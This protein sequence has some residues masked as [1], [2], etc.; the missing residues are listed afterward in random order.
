MGTPLPPIEPLPGV[1]CDRCWGSGATF[2]GG[3]PG[4]IILTLHDWTEGPLFNELFRDELTEPLTLQ[5]LG[6]VPCGFQ[7]LSEF[8]LWQWFFTTTG[9]AFS[10]HRSIVPFTS[11]SIGD[12]NEQCRQ[13]L[14]N[15][16]IAP[17]QT[18]LYGG[19]A[20]VYLGSP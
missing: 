1:L 7:G 16:N 13:I 11:A 17:E 2:P 9:T 15:D 12:S 5:Q 10:V 8:F 19:T 6:I 4:E 3:T 18:I 14:S 20:S